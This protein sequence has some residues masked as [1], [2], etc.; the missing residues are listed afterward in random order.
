MITGFV[1][2]PEN[3]LGVPGK[4]QHG[5]QSPLHAAYVLFQD[6]ISI[7]EDLLGNHF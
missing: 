4:T 2:F 3:T 1:S 5:V 6:I 7:A